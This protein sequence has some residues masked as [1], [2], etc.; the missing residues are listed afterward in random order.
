ME[1]VGNKRIFRSIGM[2]E[3]ICYFAE[4]R[5]ER[6]MGWIDAL[7]DRLGVVAGERDEG[8]RAFCLMM[9]HSLGNI[10]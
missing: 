3:G 2:Q 4:E 5:S 8:G 9:Y 6:G 10:W 1:G 7:L